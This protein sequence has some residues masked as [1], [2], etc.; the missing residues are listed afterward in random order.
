MTLFQNASLI[1]Y[2]FNNFYWLY[3]INGYLLDDFCLAK[4]PGRSS[5][6]TLFTFMIYEYENIKDILICF[7][8]LWN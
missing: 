1:I 6:K 3:I 8:T 5:L 4:I 7:F 2:C